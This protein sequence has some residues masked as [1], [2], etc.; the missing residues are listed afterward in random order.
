MRKID[1]VILQS[2]IS[3]P[4]HDK[5]TVIYTKYLENKIQTSIYV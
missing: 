5:N 2:V 4:K 3:R 1:C